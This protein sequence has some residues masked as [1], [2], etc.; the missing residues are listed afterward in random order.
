MGVGLG[1]TARVR[2]DAIG[3]EG[4]SEG[5]DLVM[6]RGRRALLLVVM[7]ALPFSVAFVDVT[8][9]AASAR[10]AD[11]KEGLFNACINN[12]PFTGTASNVQ[13]YADCCLLS[14]GHSTVEYHSD[15]SVTFSCLFTSD[16]STNTVIRPVGPITPANGPVYARPPTGPDTCGVSSAELCNAGVYG[17]Q[18]PLTFTATPIIP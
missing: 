13:F 14:G 10:S 17:L 8:A 6:K 16:P 5:G 15:G 3:V 9:T 1:P 18:P 4:L 12:V 11:A 7:A 2:A